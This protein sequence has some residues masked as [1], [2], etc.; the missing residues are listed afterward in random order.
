MEK[1]GELF[2]INCSDKFKLFLFRVFFKIFKQ[3]ELKY[4][5]NIDVLSLSKKLFDFYANIS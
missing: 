3:I 1:S 2:N 5:L 4:L